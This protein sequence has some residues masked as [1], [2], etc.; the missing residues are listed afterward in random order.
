MHELAITQDIVDGVMERMGSARVTRVIVQIGALTAVATDA[1]RFC[2]DLCAKDT[3][4]EGAELDIRG[5][6]GAELKVQAVEV[7][8]P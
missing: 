4:L 3:P 5:T 2:F 8:S 1:L 7:L 6:P